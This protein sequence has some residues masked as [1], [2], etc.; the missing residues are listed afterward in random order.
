MSA[1]DRHGTRI[2]RRG[3]SP[4][5]RRF[6]AHR[7]TDD[8]L[9]VLL[10]RR[11]IAAADSCQYPRRH[12]MGVQVKRRE[13]SPVELYE[14]AVYLL[15]SAPAAVLASYYIGALPFVM[16]L[17]FFWAD[18]TQSAVAYENCAPASM[19]VA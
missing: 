11:P 1:Q 12:H 3:T 7:R 9:A 14:E 13:K 8:R 17:L 10:R 2:A 5:V 16:G 15:R 19:V 4:R 18:M 6:A